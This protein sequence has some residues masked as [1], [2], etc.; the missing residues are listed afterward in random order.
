MPSAVGEGESWTL[1]RHLHQLS[2][3]GQLNVRRLPVRPAKANVGGDDVAGRHLLHQLAFGAD[4]GNAGGDDSGDADVAGLLNREAVET[5]IAAGAVEDASAMRREAAGISVR[6]AG[7][8][9]IEG[10]E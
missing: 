9:K 10:E 8:G 3:A 7:L 4:H 1:P 5:L 6:L 2:T